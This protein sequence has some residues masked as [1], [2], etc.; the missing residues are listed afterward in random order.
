MHQQYHHPVEDVA[1]SDRLTERTRRNTPYQN[2][3]NRTCNMETFTDMYGDAETL[4]SVSRPETLA[5][6]VTRHNSLGNIAFIDLTD[7]TGTIQ[8]ILTPDTDD[9]TQLTETVRTG[10]VI[11]ATGTPT[12]SDT[13]ALSLQVTDWTTLTTTL[14]DPPDTGAGFGRERQMT[15]RGAALRLP[16]L[17]QTIETRFDVI[18]AIRSAL[19]EDGFREVQTPV[20]HD[21]PGGAD[22]EPFVTQC[23]ATGDEMYLRIAPELYLKRLIVGGFDRIY[24]VGPVFRNEDVD[25]D[26]QPEF[27]MLEL[28]EAY[29]DWE[30]MMT[31]VATVINDAVVAVTGSSTIEYD[32]DELDF[33][34]PWS[35]MT[36][37]EAVREYTD[38]D[39]DDAVEVREAVT[40][41]DDLTHQEALLELFEQSVED[42]LVGPV[43]I[44]GY[45]ESST[46]LCASRDGAEELERFEAFAGGF[47][48]A[49]AYSELTDPVAQQEAFESQGGQQ[50]EAFVRDLA[51]GMPPTG[52]LGIGID[53]VVML[54]AGADSIKDVVP[55]PMSG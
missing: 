22:A 35:R 36:L 34:P 8:L 37:A 45:P 46:P 31:R 30:D 2:R 52:G 20:L 43:I 9:Y 23:N 16:D 32:G 14:T 19:R 42:D 7:E 28:Y 12:Y 40:K 24:E 38:V 6:R 27:T 29:A 13:G 21:V 15:R 53:R 25:T 18:A 33:S 41:A 4:E 49:N 3:T 54:V 47:E 51:Y 55:F 44:T 48:I 50:D 17:H 10:D 1:N 39:P 26:H 11:E 5:G